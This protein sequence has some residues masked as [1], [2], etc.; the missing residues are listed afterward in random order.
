MNIDFLGKKGNVVFNDVSL[1]QSIPLNE[2]RDELKEDML[3]VE[4]PGGY[5]LD[6]G[7]RPSFDINGKFY[8]CLIKDFDW[9]IP[10][11]NGSAKDIVSLLFEINQAINKL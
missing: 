8:I 10:I 4:Y 1:K 6:V 2:Q 7:W 3:Q 9:D 5:L 11:Y